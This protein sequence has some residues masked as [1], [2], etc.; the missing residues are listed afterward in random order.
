M[1]LAIESLSNWPWPE[2]EALRTAEHKPTCNVKQARF[3][4]FRLNHLTDNALFL[5]ARKIA[6][7]PKGPQRISCAFKSGDNPD[8]KTSDR[9]TLS[10]TE[11]Q[12][13]I[14]TGCSRHESCQNRER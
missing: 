4:L 7:A 2:A 1:C 5:I 12:V 14:L 9:K 10:T 6:K 3:F 13:K 8:R 11:I